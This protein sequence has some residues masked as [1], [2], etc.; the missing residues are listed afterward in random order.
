MADTARMTLFPQEL[1]PWQDVARLTA[2]LLIPFRHQSTGIECVTGGV[3]YTEIPGKGILSLPILLNEEKWQLIRLR[4]SE[5]PALRYPIPL[6]TARKFI[7]GFLS[8]ADAPNWVPRL[9]TGGDLRQDQENRVRLFQEEKL[10]LQKAAASGQIFLIDT[11]RRACR[12]LTNEVYLSSIEAVKYLETKGLID[13]AYRT[14]RDWKALLEEPNIVDLVEERRGYWGHSKALEEK[15]VLKYRENLV[16]D[17]IRRFEMNG[18][19]P[20]V[21]SQRAIVQE[22]SES[23]LVHSRMDVSMSDGG[24]LSANANMVNVHLDT[25]RSE[26]ALEKSKEDTKGLNSGVRS[27]R[28]RDVQNMLGKKSRG[29]IYT[30]MDEDPDFPKPHKLTDG[31]VNMWLESEI[32]DYIGK[33]RRG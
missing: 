32:L 19:V 17:A 27:V 26:V 28:M 23:A 18:L 1:I 2:N 6:D 30:L 10:E 20:S 8:Y 14:K 24:R 29:S 31:G 12:V 9:L 33:K 5:L 13:Q 16:L 4:L 15:G 7:D 21:V 22:T 11:T 3:T 25:I